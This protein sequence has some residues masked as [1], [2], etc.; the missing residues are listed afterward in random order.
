M[1]DPF[2]GRPFPRGPLL[3]IAALVGFALLAAIL[4]R[5]GQLGADPTLPAPFLESREL[6]FEDRPDGALAVYDTANGQ[7]VE[8]LTA[9]STGFLKG[10][11]RGF[12]RERKLH[13]LAEEVGV[14]RLAR[15]ADGLLMLKDPLTGREVF[16]GAF[17][18]TNEEVFA[19]LLAS[20]A[21]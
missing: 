9:D 12:A 14:L 20:P 6:R 11:L 17:G 10:V 16:L 21:R 1:S 7:V 2:S 4:G 3:A 8:V 19:R 5:L 13:K 15:Q 18:P